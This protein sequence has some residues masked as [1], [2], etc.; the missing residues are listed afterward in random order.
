MRARRS[1]T[2]PWRARHGSS[3]RRAGLADVFLP[4]AAPRPTK[5]PSSWPGSGA[6]STRRRLRDHHDR[7]RLPRPHAGDDVRV[8]QAGMGRACSSPRC[9][10]SRR[11]PLGDLG[12]SSGSITP[13]TVGSH[14]RADPGRGRRARGRPTTFLRGLRATDAASA[15]I[16][17][18]VDEI[19]TGIGRTGRLF[20]LRARGHR[21]RHHDARQ[22]ARRR[23]SARRAGGVRARV[24]ASSTATR[25]ARSTA[26]PLMAAVGLRGARDGARARVPRHGHRA[27]RLPARRAWRALSA[28][29]ATAR[30]VAAGFCSRST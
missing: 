16:L 8:G 25:A 23:R 14:A 24:S 5:A 2:S 13:M 11:S 7:T 28:S 9:R 18:I 3:P 19:Q 20:G 10:A 4:T 27:R 22:G 15:G 21:A 26:H 1:T 17:L 6:R 30:S 12:R 29:S